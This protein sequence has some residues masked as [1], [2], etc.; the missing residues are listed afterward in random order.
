M[1]PCLGFVVGR[2]L[3]IASAAYQKGL[4][5]VISSA[6]ESS[7]ALAH[8]ATL[9]SVLWSERCYEGPLCTIAHGLGTYEAMEEDIVAPPAKSF[10]ALVSASGSVEVSA[11]QSLLD[12][13]SLLNRTQ[14]PPRTTTPETHIP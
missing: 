8:M 5:C 13:L 12:G 10:G 1:V 14:A 9:A 3:R 4:L 2:T 6:F 11:C 7:V